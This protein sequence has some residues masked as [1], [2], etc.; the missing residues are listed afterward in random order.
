MHFDENQAAW[1]VFDTLSAENIKSEKFKTWK[2]DVFKILPIYTCKVEKI[3]KFS[4]PILKYIIIGGESIL[5]NWLL[6]LIFSNSFWTVFEK[7][8]IFDFVRFFLYWLQQ[9]FVD[10]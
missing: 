6:P 10:I 7:P 8:I 1:L 2:N 9:P 3:G 5:K 4:L